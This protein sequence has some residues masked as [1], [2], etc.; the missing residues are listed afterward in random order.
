MMPNSLKLGLGFT[1]AIALLGAMFYLVSWMVSTGPAYSSSESNGGPPP[2]LTGD[3]V[4]HYDHSNDVPLINPVRRIVQG[5]KL[6]DG[7]GFSG[8]FEPERG[9]RYM[10]I[11]TLAVNR[12]TCEALEEMGEVSEE[13][14]ERLFED[15]GLGH[16]TPSVPAPSQ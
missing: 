4:T 14:G 5:E 2:V 15:D 1:I 10:V 6:E 11:R 9:Q 13:D 12:E 3:D 8:Y 7:C 16:D